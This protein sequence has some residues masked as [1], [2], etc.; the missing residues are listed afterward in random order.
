MI[1]TQLSF[2]LKILRFNLYVTCAMYLQR[3]HKYGLSYKTSK[4]S[5]PR[6]TVELYCTSLFSSQVTT[7]NMFLL[8]RGLTMF[9]AEFTNEPT[10]IP[11]PFPPPILSPS[12]SSAVPLHVTQERFPV[13]LHQPDL[14]LTCCRGGSSCLTSS[15]CTETAPDA[16]EGKMGR[17]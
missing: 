10:P 4:H 1:A 12:S 15:V 14:A 2:S 8:P 7:R 17:A 16:P 13:P 6:C 5:K 3:K 11:V 9:S